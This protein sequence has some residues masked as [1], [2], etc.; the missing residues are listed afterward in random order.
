MI[1]TRQSVQVNTGVNTPNFSLSCTGVLQG[2]KMQGSMLQIYVASW[3]ASALG[4]VHSLSYS[5]GY[6]YG[7]ILASGA[8][9]LT[10]SITLGLNIIAL[11]AS[12]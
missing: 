5:D 7:S 11:I 10:D 2:V 8:G 3:H 6:I 12:R 9:V 4:V 1:V